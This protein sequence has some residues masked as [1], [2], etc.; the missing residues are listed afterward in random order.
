MQIKL[1]L[2]TP[3]APMER[4]NYFYIYFY[5]PN[6]LTGRELQQSSCKDVWLVERK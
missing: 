3:N 6:A 2:Q 5:Q 1:S 4:E